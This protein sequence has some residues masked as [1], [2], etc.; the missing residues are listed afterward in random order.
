[1]WIRDLSLLGHYLAAYVVTKDNPAYTTQDNL[2]EDV[3]EFMSLVRTGERAFINQVTEVAREYTAAHSPIGHV[4][5]QYLLKVCVC[6]VQR[7]RVGSAHPN[8]EAWW[9]AGGPSS[10][11]WSFVLH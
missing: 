6:H 3:R 11:N 2:L 4:I 7:S 10:E 9:H 8:T 5:E 1:M